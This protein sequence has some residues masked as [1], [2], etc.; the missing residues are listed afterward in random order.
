VFLSVQDH[1]FLE[2]HRIMDNCMLSGTTYVELAR[3]AFVH[4]TGAAACEIREVYF[5]NPLVVGRREKREMRVILEPLDQ[6]CRFSC[7]SRTAGSRERWKIHAGG[8]IAGLASG[9]AGAETLEDIRARCG[10]QTI[11][12]P[13]QDYRPYSGGVQTGPRWNCLRQVR[14][15]E[16]EGLMTLELPE[17]F[18]ADLEDYPLHPALLDKATSGLAKY[19]ETGGFLP[20]SYR[21][22]KIHAPLPRRFYAHGRYMLEENAKKPLKT[23]NFEVTLM[24]GQGGVLAAVSAFTLLTVENHGKDRVEE[25]Q[26]RYPPPSI[27]GAAGKGRTGGGLDRAGVSKYAI[28][29]EEG[30]EVFRRILGDCQPH[31]AVSTRDL[32][33]LLHPPKP[34]DLT[35]SAGEGEGGGEAVQARAVQS[36]EYVAPRS[37]T[38][39]DLARIME[40]FLGIDRVGVRDDFFELG[41]DS[42]KAVNLST[43][44]Q[45]QLNVEVPFSEIFNRPSIEEL[46]HFVEG[47]AAKTAVMDIE[48]VED[49]GF[50]PVSSQ[51]KR[52]Y[53]LRQVDAKGIA[54][55]IPFPVELPGDTALDIPRLESLFMKLIQR[56]ESLR[57]SFHLED[58]EP[59]QVIHEDAPFTIQSYDLTAA[60]GKSIDEFIR[61]FDLARAPL[62][63]AAVLKLAPDRRVLLVD[64]HHIVVDGRSLVVLVE[65]FTALLEGRQLAPLTLRY[66]DYLHWLRDRMQGGRWQEQRRYWR[67]QFKGPIPRLNLPTDFPRPA[68]QDFRGSRLSFEAG[69]ETA[70]ALGILAQTQET[71]LFMVLLTAFY[72]LLARVSRQEDIVV[73]TPA[74]GRGHPD[75]EPLIGM[76]VNTLALRNFPAAGK[77][78]AAFLSEVKQRTA[79]ALDNQEYPLEELLE[80]ID[81]KRDTSRN[82]LFDAQFQLHSQFDDFQYG[83][84]E[85]EL[86]HTAARV[87]LGLTAREDGGKIIFV[88]VYAAALFNEETRQRFRDYFNDI[89]KAVI[90]DPNITIT[91]IELS[92][93]LAAPQTDASAID[94]GF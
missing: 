66:R 68:I 19:F 75:L 89:L 81:I 18:A 87:D 32:H 61:P 16:N 58:G 5:L 40:E 30:V 6:G 35:G 54:Y 55:N 94:F 49:K 53:A 50:Y 10:R 22:L 4:H 71:T 51:Q 28:A 43:K 77:T 46:A 24:D 69:E 67:E 88:M 33:L 44:F 93:D 48:P 15:G 90:A 39:Q 17:A 36:G 63:R 72:V 37:Q 92:H 8:E 7:V 70:R 38:E 20:F 83:G 12:L 57:T 76:F 23:I 82:P 34:V 41:V 60:G 14:L 85:F 29:P 62:L 78:F 79:Q 84:K 59:V 80:M 25:A 65:D 1:W 52:L 47:G 86:E 11:D 74:A 21:D 13:P 27:L 42:L 26:Q 45:K 91:D 2:E 56:H 31:V 9:A 3:A 64:I 73:G